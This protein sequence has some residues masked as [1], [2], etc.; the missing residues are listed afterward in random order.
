MTTSPISKV[1]HDCNEANN[2]RELNLSLFENFRG[3]ILAGGLAVF[4]DPLESLRDGY[5]LLI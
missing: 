1:A 4:I 2:H 5:N 3:S